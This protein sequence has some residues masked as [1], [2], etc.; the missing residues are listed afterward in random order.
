MPRRA[1]T[2]KTSDSVTELLAGSDLLLEGRAG[3][4]TDGQDTESLEDVLNDVDDIDN[5]DDVDELIGLAVPEVLLDD[6]ADPVAK[7]LTGDDYV[8]LNDRL[9]EIRDRVRAEY[10]EIVARVGTATPEDF[11][12]RHEVEMAKRR[13]DD[14]VTTIVEANLGLVRIYVKRFLNQTRPENRADY[15]AAGMLG[16]MRA[17]HS[18]DRERGRFSSWAWR[19]IVRDTLRAVRSAEYNHVN[20]GDFEK[21][22]DILKAREALRATQEDYEPSVIEIAARAGVTT[23]QVERV[24]SAQE[25]ESLFKPLGSDSGTT[26]GEIIEDDSIGVEDQVLHAMS[27][28]A[29][30][31][32]GLSTLEPRE[33]FV[34]VRR[35]GLDGE[36]EQKLS[37]LGE[38]LGLSR[39]AVRQVEGRALAKLSHPSVLRRI[40]REGRI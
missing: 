5:S 28:E 23:R 35:F 13:L 27:L 20:V 22:P 4:L 40:A 11:D 37:K 9:F 7:V 10:E 21:R 34:L 2:P 15:E 3:L 39:E 14:A 12:Q 18:Y 24:L 29:L 32:W 36:P 38:V 25:H 26:L 30:E 1:S 16:L 31:R 6:E 17:I 33:L 19:P 8:E